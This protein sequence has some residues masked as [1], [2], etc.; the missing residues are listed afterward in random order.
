MSQNTRL[1]DYLKSGKRIN[2]LTSWR[3]LGIYRLAARVN[4][5]KEFVNIQRGWLEVKNQH[6]ELVKVREYWI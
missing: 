6:G 3:E 4:E 2:P 1:L 5:I